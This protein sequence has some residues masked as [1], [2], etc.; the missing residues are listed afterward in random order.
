[1]SLKDSFS[2]YFGKQKTYATTAS[3]IIAGSYTSDLQTVVDAATK[4]PYIYRAI[5]LRAQA[6]SNL[7]WHIVDER[8][9]E[10]PKFQSWFANP[11]FITSSDFLYKLVS[12]LDISGVAFIHKTFPQME[13]LD[14][15]S[16]SLIVSP[17][18]VKVIYMRPFLTE[19]YDISEVAIITGN[20]PYVRI[21]K[22]LSATA[23]ILEDAKSYHRQREVVS[24]LLENGAFLS[25]IF[26]TTDNLTPQQIE[27]IS[28]Q[29]RAKYASPTNAGK[30]MIL[31]G[32]DWK[33]QEIRL[34]PNDFGMIQEDDLMRRKVSILFGIPSVFFN[35]MQGVN[36]AVAQTQEYIFE[37]YVTRPLANNIAEQ[38]TRKVLDGK[39]KFEFIF[40]RNLSLEDQLLLAQLD[41]LKF[42]NGSMYINEA[43]TRD[44]LPPLPWGNEFWGN[45]SMT[46]LESVTPAPSPDLGKLYKK[47]DALEQRLVQQGAIEVK[48]KGELIWKDYI[49][50]TAPQEK[51][52]AKEVMDYF[53]RQEKY[54]LGELEKKKSGEGGIVQKI[55]VEDVLDITLPDTW[56]EYLAKQMKPYIMAYMQQAGDKTLLELGF[57]DSFNLQMPKIQE[58]IKTKLDRSALEVTNTTRD[59]LSKQLIEG[60]QNGEGIPELAGRVKTLFEETY[61]HRAETIARTEVIS[62]T[63]Y[64]RV[65][66]AETHGMQYK[67]W[68]TALDERTRPAHADANG[69]TV[70]I[71]E[72]FIVDGEDLMEPGDDNGSAENVINCR[73]TVTFSRD[74]EG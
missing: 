70:P 12:W 59:Q 74:L 3:G 33:V 31:S 28:T 37:Q 7:S 4:N 24:N 55:G 32:A 42:K 19:T 41:D 14:S 73:C 67:S 11:F 57:A 54:V 69:Q 43:R 61:P 47:L 2:K 22:D 16:V 71:D 63:N 6:L 27:N 38:L 9:N 34:N 40:T 62:A 23:T 10:M 56:V 45:L 48:T 25:V 50:M 29:I 46:P 20:S 17:N 1:M 66:A 72:P 64:A 8:G 13:L 30:T 44:N 53:K 51:R 65:D 18:S 26:T 35:D 68:L 52:L 60:V 49:A 15:D 5:Q 36:K 21:I 39:G 58:W